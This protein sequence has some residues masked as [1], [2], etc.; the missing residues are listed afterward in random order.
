MIQGA[1][2]W[3][4]QSKERPR[5]NGRFSYTPENTRKGERAIRDELFRLGLVPAEPFDDP[6][7]CE[8]YFG[9]EY[10]YFKLSPTAP[11]EQKGMHRD[12]DNMSKLVLDAFDTLMFENDKQIVDLRAVKM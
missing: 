7:A 11:A 6:L 4:P 1:I 3:T 12:V 10:F 9:A 5:H 2:P 8:L